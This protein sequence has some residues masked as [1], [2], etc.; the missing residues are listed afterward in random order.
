MDRSLTLK[1]K[2]FVESYL[3]TGNGQESARRAGYG[4]NERTLR[5]IASENLA[6]PRLQSL[7]QAR[8]QEAFMDANEVKMH[9]RLSCVE[10]WQSELDT[11]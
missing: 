7:I 8:A 1:Q 11:G 10:P 4:G 9:R 3:T 2:L 5:A 6:K